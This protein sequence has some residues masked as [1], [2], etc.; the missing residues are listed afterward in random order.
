MF[1]CFVCLFQ[2]IEDSYVSSSA[3]ASKEEDDE[4]QLPSLGSLTIGDVA[5][6]RAVAAAEEGGG[7]DD[8]GPAS[9]IF[10]EDSY[11]DASGTGL[12]E[13]KEKENDEMMEKELANSREE[14]VHESEKDVGT[15]SSLEVK[16]EAGKT[17]ASV[18]EE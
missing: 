2:F 12:E 13:F 14:E 3:A 18:K 4:S 9:G 5:L 11:V 6:A 10:I 7:Q 8:S 16:A 1:L 17:E 15:T